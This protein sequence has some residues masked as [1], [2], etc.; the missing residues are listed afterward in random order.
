MTDPDGGMI[1]NCRQEPTL[2]S[3][4]R[5][6]RPSGNT[7]TPTSQALATRLGLVAGLDEE[8]DRRPP[9]GNRDLKSDQCRK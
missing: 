3:D 4:C 7:K 2:C 9:S 5:R 6:T 1:S 8:R